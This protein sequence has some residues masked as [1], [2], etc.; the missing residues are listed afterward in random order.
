MTFIEHHQSDIGEAF[1][2][3]RLKHQTALGRRDDDLGELDRVGEDSLIVEI[4]EHA[5]GR[6]S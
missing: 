4:A 6:R 3:Q 2:L 1:G 5:D